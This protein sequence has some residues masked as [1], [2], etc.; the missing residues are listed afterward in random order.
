MKKRALVLLVLLGGIYPIYP[1]ILLYEM[2]HEHLSVLRVLMLGLINAGLLPFFVYKG[3]RL[4]INFNIDDYL[5]SNYSEI[6]QRNIIKNYYQYKSTFF[7]NTPLFTREA[8]NKDENLRGYKKEAFKAAFRLISGGLC[9]LGIL[10]VL[11]YLLV[12]V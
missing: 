9:Y 8:L 6:V 10:V 4:K 11:F 1:A 12:W 7:Q 5:T 3:L 2:R